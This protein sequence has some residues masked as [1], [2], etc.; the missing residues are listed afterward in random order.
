VRYLFA[1]YELNVRRE[2]GGSCGKC[3]AA[4]VVE[5]SERIHSALGLPL[6]R[7]V[8]ES[9]T[10]TACRWWQG[11]AIKR[12]DYPRTPGARTLVWLTWLIL[13]GAALA[14][15]PVKLQRDRTVAGYVAAPRA[16]D[17]W[18]VDLDEWP[19]TN[20]GHTRVRV[21]RVTASE[22]AATMCRYA[23]EKSEDSDECEAFAI[24]LAPLSRAEISELYAS[25]AIDTVHRDG[26]TKTAVTFLGG[27]LFAVIGLLVVHA[28]RSRRVLGG[29][30]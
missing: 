30:P 2:G 27:W 25:D 3:G 14:W 29:V 6:Q 9:S 10:C 12:P 21:D 24:R 5:T 13:L 7:R 4:T 19:G 18:E 26:D 1:M 15:I 17:I 23:Y 11:R 20:T 22:V 16:G 8:Y 28:R